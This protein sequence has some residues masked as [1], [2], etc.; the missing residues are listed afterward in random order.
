[1]WKESDTRI[2]F[3]CKVKERDEVVISNAAIELYEE[4]PKPAAEAHAAAA[5]AGAG[6]GAAAPRG[7]A[8][9]RHLH[10]PWA[11]SSA[12][13][14]EVADK[15]ETS[16]SSSSASPDSVWTIDL[17]N[18]EVVARARPRRPSAPWR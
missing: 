2:V 8:Q 17:K 15:V 14:P 3:R 5:A 6:A 10:A 18:G 4:I 13:T 12:Q 7:A 1:M 16:S 11:A 9:R